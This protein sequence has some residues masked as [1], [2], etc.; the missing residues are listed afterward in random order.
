MIL[1]DCK[2]YTRIPCEENFVRAVVALL[3]YEI[4]EL[5]SQ[6]HLV[7][8]VNNSNKLGIQITENVEKEAGDNYLKQITSI[9]REVK[10]NFIVKIH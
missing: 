3:P 10:A 5:L 7:F 2:N 4:Q 1:R 6:G 9:A 8:H